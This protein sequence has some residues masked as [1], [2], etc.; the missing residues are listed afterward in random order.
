MPA[1]TARPDAQKGILISSAE[2]TRRL[3]ERCGR[4][5]A[6]PLVLALVGDLGSGKTVFVQGLARGLD[7]P[8]T[9]YVTSP[10]YTLINE[11]PGRLP[12]VHI[13]LYRLDGDADREELG[14]SEILGAEA[15]TAVE[16]ADKL[17]PG[18]AAERHEIR[19]ESAGGDCRTIRL[20]AYGQAA[21]SLLE[22][23][24]L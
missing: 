19:F 5:I 14:M 22:A 4:L 2:Q 11:Y 23:L 12:L 21:R 15:A 10:S 18:A 24:A 1:V 17:P 16:W 8:D 7:V 6:G 20:E 13:D 3:G 9:F